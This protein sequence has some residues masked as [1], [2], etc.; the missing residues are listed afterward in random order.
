MKVL[1][2]GADNTHIANYLKEQENLFVTMDIIN[3]SDILELGVEFIVSYNYRYKIKEEIINKLKG[4]IINLH[5]SYLPWNRG[6]DPN[7]WSIAQG[8]PKGVTIHEVNSEIDKGEILL[9]QEI[10][11]SD[12]ETLKTSYE[13]LHKAIQELFVE[14]WP[15]LKNM[16]IKPVKQIGNGSFHRSEEKN[17]I[18]KLLSKSWDTK[19]SDFKIICKKYNYDCC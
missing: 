19:I 17:E 3:I 6:A 16:E 2:L 4:R 9:Q 7:F 5:I 10:F 8:T 13:I 11:F 15:K 1:L 14:N 12:E 18:M